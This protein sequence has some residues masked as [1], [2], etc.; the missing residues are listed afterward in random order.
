MAVRAHG[1]WH[2][3]LSSST[4]DALRDHLS[5]VLC[6]LIGR[7]AFWNFQKRSKIYYNWPVRKL[8]ITRTRKINL[9]LNFFS[10]FQRTEEYRQTNENIHDLE[11]P[12]QRAL[13]AYRS[14]F[15]QAIHMSLRWEP[16]S[17][18]LLQELH[19]DSCNPIKIKDKDIKSVIDLWSWS[20]IL[21]CNS[22]SLYH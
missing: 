13:H 5:R 8:A 12:K 18:L 6:P 21:H 20:H 3:I 16:L 7:S 22:S 9:N 1:G 17:S 10:K 11:C 4:S 14:S 19:P 15:H 2:W